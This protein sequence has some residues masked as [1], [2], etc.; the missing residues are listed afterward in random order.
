MRYKYPW[1]IFFK[2]SLSLTN[3]PNLLSPLLDQYLHFQKNLS[4]IV[5][6]Q[7]D[8]FCRKPF[9]QWVISFYDSSCEPFFYWRISGNRCRTE[10]KYPNHHGTLVCMHLC[11]GIRGGLF[12]GASVYIQIPKSRSW[13]STSVYCTFI[14]S[15]SCEL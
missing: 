8:Q 4:L 15:T 10:G 1:Y 5:A 2:K 11:L 9:K 3:F 13:P 12:A 6:V 7:K 14:A